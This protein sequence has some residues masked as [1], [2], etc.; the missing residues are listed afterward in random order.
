MAA[1]RCRLIT[2]VYFFSLAYVAATLLA[3][4]VGHLRGF[5]Q[6]RSLVRSHG[7]V[8]ARFSMPISI[9]VV[10]VELVAGSFA[11]AILFGPDAATRRSLLLAACSVVACAFMLYVRQLLLKPLGITSCGCTPIASPLTPASIVPAAALLLVSVAGFAATAFRP[12]QSPAVTN[13]L[14]V[15]FT[16]LPVI[17]GVTLAGIIILVPASIPQLAVERRS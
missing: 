4:G 1:A 11:L 6:F 2:F 14:A 8:R 13:D 9:F 15:I 3:G 16:A 17:S 5:A 10:A 12:G 7:I